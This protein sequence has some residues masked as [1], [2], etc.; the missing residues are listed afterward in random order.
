MQHRGHLPKSGW[1]WQG[2]STKLS[3]SKNGLASAHGRA[4]E[5]VTL[6]APRHHCTDQS[7]GL[8][9]FATSASET[10]SVAGHWKTS[11]DEKETGAKLYKKGEAAYLRTWSGEAE[12]RK[13]A[14][15]GRIRSGPPRSLE[16][17]APSRAKSNLHILAAHA[18]NK[19]TTSVMTEDQ[20]D[21][22]A[23]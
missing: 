7:L 1:Q 5:R 16:N 12:V 23:Q 2:T 14:R 22:R 19:A 18:W 17:I 15:P 3:C 13:H 8:F 21:I 20:T 11:E 4:L 6:A 10:S 9:F